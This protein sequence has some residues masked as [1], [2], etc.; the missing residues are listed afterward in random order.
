MVGGS[1]LRPRLPDHRGS[2]A[3]K[4]RDASKNRSHNPKTIDSKH[5]F[6]FDLTGRSMFISFF[7]DLTGRSRP[8]AA[9]K[10]E[11]LNLLTLNPEPRTQNPEPLNPEP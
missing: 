10:L 2:P 7:F 5:S 4:Q 1:G 6:F 9:L 3:K 11:P 8:A